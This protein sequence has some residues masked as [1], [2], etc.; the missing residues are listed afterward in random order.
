MNKLKPLGNS[1]TQVETLLVCWSVD[2][3]QLFTIY[4]EANKPGWT[5]RDQITQYWISLDTQNNQ[6]QRFSY[7]LSIETSFFVAVSCLAQCGET[8][9][10]ARDLFGTCLPNGPN[11]RVTGGLAPCYRVINVRSHSVCLLAWSYDRRQPLMNQ[12]A[13]TRDSM[14]LI[15]FKT[16][17]GHTMNIFS[18]YEL[19]EQETS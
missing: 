14:D 7:H 4:V 8:Q 15:L 1:F 5:L 16:Q 6:H 9:L 11:L 10:A 3:T 13:S 2:L 18:T 17:G 19:A 12:W